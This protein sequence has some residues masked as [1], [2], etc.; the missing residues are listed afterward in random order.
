M[1]VPAG[2]INPEVDFNVPKSLDGL[3][4]RPGSW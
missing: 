3:S 1:W 4:F 2:P